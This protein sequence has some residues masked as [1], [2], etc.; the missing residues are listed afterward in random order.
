M[1]IDQ[2]RLNTKE[3]DRKKHVKPAIFIVFH[4]DFETIIDE[5]DLSSTS[6]APSL[7]LQL[8]ALLLA[9]AA[10]LLRQRRSGREARGHIFVPW[11]PVSRLESDSNQPI[12]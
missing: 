4:S 6:R 10:W 9:I 5:I 3:K 2:S 11:R 8:R 12:S 1:K 7:L